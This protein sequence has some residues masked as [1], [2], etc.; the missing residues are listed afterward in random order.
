MLVHLGAWNPAQV[1]DLPAPDHRLRERERLDAR[2][3]ASADGHEPG[4]HLVVGDVAAQ[5]ARE[6]EFDLLGG[7]LA[8]IPLAADHLERLHRPKLHSN[9]LWATIARSGS[10]RSLGTGFV[11]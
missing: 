8:A 6:Q 1:E 10:Y 4:R 3:A 2:H 9:R 11:Q 5:V 7:V